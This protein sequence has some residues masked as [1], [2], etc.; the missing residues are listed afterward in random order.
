MYGLFQAGKFKS[1]QRGTAIQFIN[2][3]DVRDTIKEVTPSVYDHWQ[4]Y[5]QVLA[6]LSKLEQRKVSLAEQVIATERM[7]KHLISSYF[8][9]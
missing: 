8:N 2:L 4:Q 7:Q 1:C 9:K 5:Q 6:A 3:Q